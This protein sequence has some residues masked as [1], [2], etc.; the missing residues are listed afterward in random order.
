MDTI[1]PSAGWN[2]GGEFLVVGAS[3]LPTPNITQLG[4]GVLEGIIPFIMKDTDTS[5][6]GGI[7]VETDSVRVMNGGP[8]RT[9]ACL[10]FFGSDADGRRTTSQRQCLD[11]NPQAAGIFTGD[12]L[13]PSGLMGYAEVYSIDLDGPATGPCAGAV[14]ALTATPTAVPTGVSAVG[15]AYGVSNLYTS[16][17]QRVVTAGNAIGAANGL[18]CQDVIGSVAACG[19]GASTTVAANQ[20]MTLPVVIKNYGGTPDKW[21]TIVQACQASGVPARQP[22]LVEFWSVNGAPGGFA[23]PFLYNT[24]A[25]PGGCVTFNLRDL[26]FLPD[27]SPYV[28]NVT[29]TGLVGTVPVTPGGGLTFPNTFFVSSVM[30]TMGSG[31]FPGG[32]ATHT[33]GYAPLTGGANTAGTTPLPGGPVCLNAICSSKLYGPLI[34]SDYVTGGGSWW[35]GIALSNFPSTG[36]SG[37]TAVTLT[38]IDESGVTRGVVNDR[39]G[40]DSTTVFWLGVQPGT[41]NRGVWNRGRLLVPLDRN[42]RGA[43]I[44]DVADATGT[45]SSSTRRPFAMVQSTNYARKAHTSYNAVRDEAINPTSFGLPAQANDS[46]V[47]SMQIN[48]QLNNP[49][50]PTGLTTVPSSANTGAANPA[51]GGTCLWA[52]EIHGAVPQLTARSEASGVRMFNPTG[53]VITVDVL[54]FDSA[55]IE[56]TDS[57]TTFSIGPFSTA[58]IF[59]GTDFRLPPNFN[60]SVYIAATCSTGSGPTCTAPLAAMSATIDY[61]VTDHDTARAMN[62]PAQS[63][64]T[65]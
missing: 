54:Y 63:G 14:P 37:S 31:A 47:C 20:M 56:W 26:A 38:V 53:G 64:F 30:Y 10:D 57:R 16:V 45:L 43:F 21:D 28:V 3:A 23:A 41:E 1:I 51:T 18:T 6:T 46:R 4:Q 34:Y 55:G 48:T 27:G 44:M 11:L 65:Q 25:D 13:L 50:G 22:L 59:T 2:A 49:P 32:A 61:S 62:L 9:I 36:S 15:C 29:S 5:R 40:A 35:T 24:S 8:F 42:F 12:A 60:G 7:D 58:T 33:S 52:P 39:P 19:S 17:T